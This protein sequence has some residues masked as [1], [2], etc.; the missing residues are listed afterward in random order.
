VK[1]SIKDY[2]TAAFRFYALHDRSAEKYKEKIRQEAIEKVEERMKVQSQKGSPT[3]SALMRSEEAI[4]EKIAEICDLE[5]VEKMLAQLQA[6][7]KGYILSA[8]EYVYFT[9]PNKELCKCDI[10]D[11]VRAA[12]IEIPAGERSIYRWLKQA[13]DMFA[14]ERGLRIKS[15]Q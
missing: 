12:S 6:N 3:E 15:W 2:A 1:D 7:N 5:A 9:E 13:R 14:Y 8:I 4:N 10:Q 11:R